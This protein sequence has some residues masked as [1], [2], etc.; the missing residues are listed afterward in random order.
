[1]MAYI[2]PSWMQEYT[3]RM[4]T[5]I[6]YVQENKFADAIAALQ[7]IL[8]TTF[9]HDEEEEGEKFVEDQKQAGQKLVD[10]QQEAADKEQE[11]LDREREADKAA[12]ERKAREQKK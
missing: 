4:N 11:K 12:D 3:V 5:N 6:M 10:D 2:H 9:S 7:N 8:F 1:M